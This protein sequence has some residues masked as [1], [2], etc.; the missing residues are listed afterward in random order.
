MHSHF[1]SPIFLQVIWSRPERFFSTTFSTYWFPYVIQIKHEESLFAISFLVT[2]SLEIFSLDN[3]LSPIF[4]DFLS[5]L[6]RGQCFSRIQLKWC[7]RS[8]PH[9]V[10][11]SAVAVDVQETWCNNYWAVPRTGFLNWCQFC[12]DWRQSL[13]FLW[14]FL[15]FLFLSHLRYLRTLVRILFH[16]HAHAH[17]ISYA[18][19][20]AYHFISMTPHIQHNFTRP[21]WLASRRIRHIGTHPHNVHTTLVDEVWRL[22]CVGICTNCHSFPAHE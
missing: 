19:S 4:V 16:A 20:C 9:L 17:I 15:V 2:G 21:W 5:L 13:I 3:V 12:H 7:S 10:M 14:L 22:S 11:C 1:D 18:R 8:S 6:S